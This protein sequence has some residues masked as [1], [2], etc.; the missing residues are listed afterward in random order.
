MAEALAVE[1]IDT[2]DVDDGKVHR[3][4]GECAIA[5]QVFW[6]DVRLELHGKETGKATVKNR[7]R[8][9]ATSKNKRKRE[10]EREKTLLKKGGIFEW[11]P[12]SKV[13]YPLEEGTFDG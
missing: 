11:N 8:D 3:R 2:R 9:W 10:R 1:G 13:R 7:E 4:Q 6:S 5:H 12:R